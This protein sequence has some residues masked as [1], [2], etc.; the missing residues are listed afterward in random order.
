MAGASDAGTGGGISIRGARTENTY[1]YID[2]VKVPAGAGPGLPITVLEAIEPITGGIPEEYLAPPHGPFNLTSNV[3]VSGRV[4][5]EDGGPV[6][7]ASIRLGETGISAISDE[8]GRFVVSVPDPLYGAGIPLRVLYVGYATAE[9]PLGGEQPTAMLPLAP[10][11][12]EGKYALTGRALFKDK[13]IPGCIIEVV[14]TDQRIMAEDKG[15]FGFDVPDGQ[16]EWTVRALAPDGSVGSTTFPASALPCCVPIALDAQEKR[17]DVRPSSID[18]GDIVLEPREAM[19]MGMWIETI[20]AK[21][22]LARRA[23]APFRWVGR[24]VSRPLR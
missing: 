20:P 10:M 7:F 6:P 8:G 24:Q 19:M 1:Y 5:G 18:M 17:V 2:G 15:F 14:G 4:L 3:V 23:G 16:S 11:Y 9:V 12:V 13:P 22:S 21:Q